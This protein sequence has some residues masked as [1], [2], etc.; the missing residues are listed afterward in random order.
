MRP[1][2]KER[3][4]GSFSKNKR[5]RDAARCVANDKARGLN[6]LG[7]NFESKTE[8]KRRRG[9]IGARQDG[10]CYRFAFVALGVLFWPLKCATHIGDSSM[11]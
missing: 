3:R 9:G 8:L 10:V 6:D 5:A 1:Q 7:V 11:R 2:T 4:I